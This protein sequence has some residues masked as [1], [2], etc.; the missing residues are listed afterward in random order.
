MAFREIA[1][2]T[3]F[4]RSFAFVS[5]ALAGL[6][7]CF[8]DRLHNICRTKFFGL[9]AGLYCRCCCWSRLYTLKH[10]QATGIICG[11][12]G[13]PFVCITA[14]GRGALRIIWMAP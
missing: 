14:L 13:L 5:C 8:G 7:F 9:F 2:N 10:Q 11:A 1:F 3:R 12:W 4:E 6:H